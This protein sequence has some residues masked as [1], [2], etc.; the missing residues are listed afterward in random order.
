[1]GARAGCY[2]S[3]NVRTLLAPVR[4]VP[5]SEP[6]PVAPGMD[7]VPRV[8]RAVDGMP[9]VPVEVPVDPA[10]V[11]PVDAAPVL[12]VAG[13]VLVPELMVPLPAGLLTGD[14]TTAGNEHARSFRTS[15]AHGAVASVDSVAEVQRRL[16][17]PASAPDELGPGK[18]WAN[19]EPASRSA[20]SGASETAEDLFMAYSFSERCCGLKSTACGERISLEQAVA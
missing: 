15:S 6:V 12:P 7:E 20:A 1:M 13:W 9:G 5:L 11:V 14:R 10:P 2:L 3:S 4:I 19:A 18:V 17:R 8:Q 16:T